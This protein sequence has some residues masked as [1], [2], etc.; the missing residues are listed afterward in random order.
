MHFSFTQL[1]LTAEGLMK[2]FIKTAVC[3][4][5]ALIMSFC[6]LNETTFA[7]EN[8]IDVAA[9]TS[10]NKD[11]WS[12]D[13]GVWTMTNSNYANLRY[14]V[15]LEADTKIV[16][17][18]DFEILS[19]KINATI[20]TLDNQFLVTK[21]FDK[22]GKAVLQYTIAESGTYRFQICGTSA[23]AC[24]KISSISVAVY[25]PELPSEYSEESLR[26]INEVEALDPNLSILLFADNHSYEENKYFK[27]PGIMK[28]GVVDYQIGL[29]DYVDYSHSP[30]STAKKL[31]ENCISL[32]GKEA[33]CFYLYGNHDVG[34]CGV[35]GG[36]NSL[37]V[38]MTPEENYDIF[39]KHLESNEN[40]HV[41]PLN[42]HGGYY[43]VDDESAKIRMIILN[44]S[45][46]FNEN[47]EIPSYIRYQ[48]TLRVSQTQLTW[49]ASKALDFSDKTN[50]SAWSVI[51]FGHE[52]SPYGNQL[53]LFDILAAAQNGTAI[54]KSITVYK[55]LTEIDDGNYINT[56]DTEN[57]DIYSVSMDYSK[58]GP[59]TVI[60][61]IHGHNHVDN[62]SIISGIN[63][64][65]VRCDN[66]S[67]DRYYIASLN[68]LS[69]GKYYFKD[70]DGHIYVFSCNSIPDAA[71]VGYNYYWTS[72]KMTPAPIAVFDKNGL[73]LK[74]I[75]CSY[76]EEIPED[77]VEITDFVSERDESLAGKESCE[78]LCIDKEAATITFIPYGTG[79]QRTFSYVK[80]YSDELTL[81]DLNGDEK[82]NVLDANLVRRYAAEL[83]KLD[84]K[85]LVSADVNGDG[86]V[87]VL[88]A[89]LIRRFAAKLIDI[90]PA[91]EQ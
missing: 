86:K 12:Y 66:G 49:F 45:D 33:N 81:G 80:N 34:I 46:I 59:I 51:V 20:R 6:I 54:E 62:N 57:G 37:D 17:S 36:S 29:G 13:N 23:E 40:V 3:F 72:A 19:G 58:Q 10:A 64:I 63:R 35:N 26:V 16:F 82:V 53:I 31:L 84:E 15:F 39:V 77:A 47:S 55:R 41:D 21:N 7:E 78:I 8:L 32:S 11:I 89:N 4:L 85:L 90:F 74:S 79:T 30:K 50:P 1:F 18:F 76:S 56:I 83:D 67:I 70:I 42:P 91:A 22:D 38:V 9:P 60:G 24:A 73:R 44:T 25:V 68:G 61:F 28:Y 2:N 87:N 71:A 14:D 69:E 27:Y 75:S 48:Q 43:Y 65:Q 88:D 5:F 52:Y